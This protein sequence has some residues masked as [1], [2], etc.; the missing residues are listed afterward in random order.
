MLDK[1]LLI[2]VVSV[3][4]PMELALAGNGFSAY[5]TLSLLPLLKAI[6]HGF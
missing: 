1:I 2:V 4:K 3:N 5:H 6:N